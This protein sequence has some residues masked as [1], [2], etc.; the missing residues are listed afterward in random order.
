MRPARAKPF[1]RNELERF[2]WADG[3]GAR[4]SAGRL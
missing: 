2:A 3:L 1:H 4:V